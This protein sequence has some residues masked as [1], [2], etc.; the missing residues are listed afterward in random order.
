MPAKPFVYRMISF[1]HDTTQIVWNLTNN[2]SG[3][4]NKKENP[5]PEKNRGGFLRVGK[6]IDMNRKASSSWFPASFWNLTISS[7]LKKNVVEFI[8]PSI[9]VST[10][11]DVV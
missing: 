8:T 7:F 5:L 1:T 4:F 10:T 3:S 9:S 6:T 2:A 11:V